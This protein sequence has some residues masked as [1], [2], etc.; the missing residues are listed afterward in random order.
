MS[1]NDPDLKAEL[2]KLKAQVR[3]LTEAQRRSAEEVPRQE[4]EP[5]AASKPHLTAAAIPV[6]FEELVELLHHELEDL[7]PLTALAIFG[8]GVLTGR[9]LAH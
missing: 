5:D 2:E 7:N 9:L 8:L 3:A 6:D 1:K 4:P